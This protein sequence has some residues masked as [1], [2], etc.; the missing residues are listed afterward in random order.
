MHNVNLQV[1]QHLNSLGQTDSDFQ[2]GVTEDNSATDS[3]EDHADR[4]QHQ[5]HHGQDLANDDEESE[6]D[7]DDEDD[8]TDDEEEEEDREINDAG[9]LRSMLLESENYYNDLAEREAKE[10]KQC[11]VCFAVEEDDPAALWTHPC[12]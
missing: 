11:W 2:D 4:V 3:E 12:R 8:L 10:E 9:L 1:R 7:E 5:C 6:D